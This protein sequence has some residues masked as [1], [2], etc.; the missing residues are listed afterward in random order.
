MRK[1]GQRWAAPLCFGTGLALLVQSTT[2]PP[3][4]AIE[5]RLGPALVA[6]GFAVVFWGFV[7][8]QNILQLLAA[9]KGKSLSEGGTP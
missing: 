7:T 3:E 2:Q 6:L 4:L 9:L 5:A 1:S 8:I